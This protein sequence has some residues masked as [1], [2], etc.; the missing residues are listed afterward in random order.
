MRQAL[1]YAVNREG[2]ISYVRN[3]LGT[4]GDYGFVPYALPSF[5]SSRV[6][7]Y[8]YNLKKA[9]ELLKEAG[10]PEGKGLPPLKLNTY[11]SDAEI[12]EHLRKDWK[13]IG[14]EVSIEKNQFGTHRELVG[15]AKANMFR[16][17][18][19]GDYPDAENYLALFYS[20]NNPPK[21]PNFFHFKDNNFD[22]LFEEAHENSNTFIRYEDYLKMDQIIMEN[23]VVIPLYYDEIIQLKQQ[24]VKGLEIN[25]MNNLVLKYVDFSDIKK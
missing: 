10:F 24:Y 17:S 18:W 25:A 6:Q 14:V 8:P 22:K 3:G 2:L 1:S 9:Q 16:G 15:N 13:E 4:K 7:G 11:A 21:G 20:K 12:A 23:A 5:D 19:L